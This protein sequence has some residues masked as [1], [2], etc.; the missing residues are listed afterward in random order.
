[1]TRCQAPPAA[2]RVGAEE[3]EGEDAMGNRGAEGEK[4]GEREGESGR[5]GGRRRRSGG[6]W[7]EAVAYRVAN[8]FTAAQ[9][10]EQT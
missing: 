9:T 7:G 8:L 10:E 2:R 1:M 3:P 4:E 5:R 6:R